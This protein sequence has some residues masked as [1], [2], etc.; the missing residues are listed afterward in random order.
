MAP[1]TGSLPLQRTAA[2]VV[3]DCFLHA[4]PLEKQKAVSLSGPATPKD[5]LEALKSAQVNLEISKGEQ[6]LRPYITPEPPFTERGGTQRATLT[7]NP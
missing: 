2:S 5:M 6:L 1:D 7:G 3:M 4:L